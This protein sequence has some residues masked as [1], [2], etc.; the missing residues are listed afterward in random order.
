MEI[1]RTTN[2]ASQTDRA[3][4][5]FGCT[6]YVAPNRNLLLLLFDPGEFWLSYLYPF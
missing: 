2:E 6:I 1:E 3:R 4:L 5:R